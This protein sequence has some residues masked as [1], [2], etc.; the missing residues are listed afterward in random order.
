MCILE[1]VIKRSS[2]HDVSQFVLPNVS[3]SRPG[4]SHGVSYHYL[5]GHDRQFG[6]QHSASLGQR[7]R[8]GRRVGREFPL[9][10]YE[11]DMVKLWIYAVLLVVE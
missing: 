11:G 4:H 6:V 3:F 5:L 10:Y 2:P 1:L 9:F 8:T 7:E